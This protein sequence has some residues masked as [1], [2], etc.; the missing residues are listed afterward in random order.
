MKNKIYKLAQY[1]HQFGLFRALSILTRFALTSRN[2]V[3]SIQLPTLAHP[4]WVRNKSSDEFTMQQIFL[5]GEYDF[6][7]EKAPTTILDAGANIGLAAVYFANRFPDATII[8]LEPEHGNFELLKKNIAPYPNL[9]AVQAGLWWKTT[10]LQVKDNGWGN[11][12]FTVEECAPG[13]P[14]A[15]QAY[16]VADV[17]KKFS[18][19]GAD[20]I[21]I[22]IEGSEKQVLEAP[23]VHD[24]VSKCHTL[25]VEHHD[26]MVADSSASL[27]VSYWSIIP[28]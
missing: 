16:S 15:I 7:V 20:M 8:C 5:F 24:W 4:I 25:V 22:D 28:K 21:K 19:P 1:A 23:D 18:L 10:F 27:F 12:G 26:R 3:I 2:K 13:T 11:W 14:G 9:V 6:A 17:L